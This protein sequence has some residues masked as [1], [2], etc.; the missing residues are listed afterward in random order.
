MPL[1]TN[2]PKINLAKQY[3]SIL[4]S[5]FDDDIVSA[6]LFGSVARGDDTKQ[7]DI[8]LMVIL[9]KPPAFGQ[10]RKLGEIGRF[11]EIRGKGKFEK[12]SCVLVSKARFLGFIRE[13]APREAVNPLREA[14][15][16]YDSGFIS[17][18]KGKIETDA[19]S[20]KKDAYRDY[21]RYGNIRRSCLIDS[22]KEKNK[23][24][25]HS[26]AAKA[27]SHYLRAYFLHKY[28]EMILSKE[29]LR[30]RI[31]DEN[32]AISMLYETITNG[33][34]SIYL[35]DKIR[36]WSIENIEAG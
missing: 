7:S 6:F 18:L 19:I 10:I 4:T 32:S 9:K 21:L 17:R 2:P 11:G 25:A 22:T 36:E 31:K 20:L 8:D 13:K 12:I 3:V 24:D 26:D 15:I 1:R 14:L 28:N 29:I 33:D 27:A 5:V 16:L 34:Y 35:V 30:T 23:R